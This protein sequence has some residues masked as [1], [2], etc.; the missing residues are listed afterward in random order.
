M[1]S[2]FLIFQIGHVQKFEFFQS[3]AFLPRN[4]PKPLFRVLRNI[5]HYSIRKYEY[6]QKIISSCFEWDLRV[7]K[8]FFS[9]HWDPMPGCLF[10]CEG[11]ASIAAPF[12]CRQWSVGCVCELV[13]QGRCT[14]VT[15]QQMFRI[16]AL[17]ALALA[18][19]Q[20]VL[21]LSGV[22]YSDTQATLQGLLIAG[23]FFCISRS[24][25]TFTLSSHFYGHSSGFNAK[26][27][28][29]AASSASRPQ[30]YSLHVFILLLPDF[31]IYCLKK[32]SANRTFK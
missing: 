3:I 20:S 12:T 9:V 29:P 27:S 5:F 23:C 22:R 32:N 21:Y 7:I 28:S 14:L 10:E 17:N 25:V 6:V 4:A 15:T 11:D 13:K 19:S 30:R 8:F 24:K 2:F 31:H 1:Q 18:Y 16:L 26:C